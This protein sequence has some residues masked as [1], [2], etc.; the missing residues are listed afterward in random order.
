MRH[1]KLRGMLDSEC[2]GTFGQGGYN[3]FTAEP[4]NAGALQ[5]TLWELAVLQKHFQPHV[6]GM[7]A[8]VAK[9]PV[10]GG[11]GSWSAPVSAGNDA[12]QVASIYAFQ[13]T[14][15]FRP[16]RDSSQRKKR[17]SEASKVM[18]SDTFELAARVY[19]GSSI[20]PRVEDAADSTLASEVP[21]IFRSA[22]G[23]RC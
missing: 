8:A 1:I 22:S 16:A 10:D 7:A 21:Q 13:E 12:A 23:A 3:P 6:V 17:S 20:W 18:P 15:L 5:S 14:G 11:A 4:G 19:L 9:I 2:F